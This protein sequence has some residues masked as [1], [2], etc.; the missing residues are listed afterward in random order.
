[1]N[2]WNCRGL[3]S[4]GAQFGGGDFITQLESTQS[5]GD[6]VSF[7]G[8]GISRNDLQGFIPGIQD[9]A[10]TALSSS[11]RNRS[12]GN[13]CPSAGA[14]TRDKILPTA[15]FFLRWPLS[16]FLYRFRRILPYDG[17]AATETGP[18]TYTGAAAMR[19]RPRAGQ[20]ENKGK[21][22]QRNDFSSSSSSSTTL[23]IKLEAFL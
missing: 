19:N 1:M 18:H 14:K 23:T 22:A 7:F 17:V 8:E 12:W 6:F 9:N 16:G 2:C 4:G 11:G 3:P 10:S 15:L 13:P 5:C 21:K 20:D